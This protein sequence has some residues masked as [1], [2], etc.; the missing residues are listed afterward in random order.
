M[1][2]YNGEEYVAAAIDSVLTQS[3][4]AFE[5][6]IIDDGSTDGSTV[7]LRDYAARDDRIRLIE[8]DNTGLTIAL[9]RGV[10]A[11][12]GK[13]VARMD[14]DDLSTPDRFARQVTA[15]EADPELAAV[16]CH[17]EHFYDD[18][19]LSHV[20]EPRGDP[21]LI[22]L[23][24]CFTNRIGGHGQI[25]LRRSAYDL[26]GG[27]DP[28]YRYA[29]DYDLWTRLTRHGSFGVIDAMLYRFRTGHGSISSRSSEGQAEN[30]LRICQREYERLT[31][32][33]IEGGVARAMH[34]FWWNQPP[35][36]T[37]LLDTWRSSI[38][39]ARAVR[40][41]FARLPELRRHE[42]FVRRG[43]AAKWRWRIKH[44]ESQDSVRKAA[45]LVNV[46]HWGLT[47]LLAF[48]HR[49]D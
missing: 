9:C 18:G 36:E 2:V 27:Y 47:A 25:M 17:V 28:S 23:Y 33:S 15:L 49:N 45:L 41:F 34:N 6:I 24:N 48:R 4:G 44:T 12:V 7:I 21:R 8:Q 16:T 20:A 1:S 32:R 5:F 26:A 22:P 35:S 31:G 42:F 40:V 14:A 13:F 38:A 39:M 3:F 29:Q 11:S 37:S 30:S 19:S 43:I 10:E 46:L